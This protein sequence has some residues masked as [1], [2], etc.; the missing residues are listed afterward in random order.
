MLDFSNEC[1]NKD[2][3]ECQGKVELCDTCCVL[4]CIC[5]K[6]NESLTYNRCLEFTGTEQKKLG[7]REIRK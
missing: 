6:Q 2:F 5:L 3:H 4:S 1:H 7:E